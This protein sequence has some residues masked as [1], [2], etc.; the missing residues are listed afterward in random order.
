[1]K[2]FPLETAIF[3][4]TG[5]PAGRLGLQDR[6]LIREG[7]WA[8]LVLFDFDT[9]KDTPD[10]SKP[11]QPCEGIRRVY[12]NGVLTAENGR[13]TGARSGQI[14]RRGKGEK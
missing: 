1:Q 8:D 14:L 6:G 7:M 2:L 10:Y 4:M 11:K 13:H 9:I 12:V 3:K 5:L